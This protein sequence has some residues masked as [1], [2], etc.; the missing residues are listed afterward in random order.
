MGFLKGFVE[1]TFFEDRF[2]VNRLTQDGI[3]EV[4]VEGDHVVEQTV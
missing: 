1:T 4:V 3:L 2:L